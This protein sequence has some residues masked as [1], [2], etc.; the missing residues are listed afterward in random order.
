MVESGVI[1]GEN[2]ILSVS[3][4]DCLNLFPQNTPTDFLVQLP[5]SIDLRENTWVCTLHQA[6]TKVTDLA[7]DTI[8]SIW[9]SLL[10]EQYHYGH[11]LPVLASYNL[12]NNRRWQSFNPQKLPRN[13]VSTST[14]FI[15]FK[16][17][18]E[19]TLAAL[20][21]DDIKLVLKI[22]KTK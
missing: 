14:N 3:W 21:L 9:C 5:K 15:H 2:F 18:T 22:E 19:D 20:A 10:E 11:Y 16:V 17:L 7:R 8:I 6:F 12:K 1:M 13:T 4:K